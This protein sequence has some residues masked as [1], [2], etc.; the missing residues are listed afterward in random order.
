MFATISIFEFVWLSGLV[1]LALTAGLLY[2]RGLHREFPWF[3]AYLLLVLLRSPVLY[4]LKADRTTYFYS[5][6]IVEGITVCLSLLV[7]YEIYRHVLGASS[8]NISRTS[9]FALSVGLFAVAAITAILIETADSH[10]LLRAVFILTRTA[11][12]VQVGLL[13]LLLIASMFFNFYWQSL[14]FGFALGYGI[15]ATVELVVTTFRS[16]LGAAGDNIF[17]L[18]K[19]LSYQ[20]AVLVWIVFIYRHRQGHS[21]QTLPS[22]SMAE[23]FHPV[24]R[25]AK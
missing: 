12:I 11:R 2:V 9:F 23:W 6:W 10:V 22:E 20:V 7:I 19:V 8:L 5:Y 1:L 4:F 3:F 15:Y 13:I 18:S 21:L 16:S 25:T 17:A 14:P 24:G